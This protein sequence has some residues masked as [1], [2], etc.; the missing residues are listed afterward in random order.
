MGFGYSERWFSI[1]TGGCLGV[2]RLGGIPRW[3]PLV[4]P[5]REGEGWALRFAKGADGTLKRLSGYPAGAGPL[6]SALPPLGSRFRGNDGGECRAWA[7]VVRGRGCNGFAWPASAGISRG[8]PLYLPLHRVGG[9]G[10]APLREAKGRGAGRGLGD[11]P[12][13]RSAS[14]RER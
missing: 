9:K 6:V 13:T 4:F 7:D 10:L 14:S 1:R 5:L 8:T 12:R 11:P 2:S 3:H